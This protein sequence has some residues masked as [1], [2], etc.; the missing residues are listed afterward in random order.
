MK[1]KWKKSISEEN[2][3]I[4][5]YVESFPNDMWY[6]NIFKSYI[7]NIA[8]YWSF[9]REISTF[10]IHTKHYT[11][12]SAKTCLETHKKK[13]HKVRGVF[14]VALE[15]PIVFHYHMLK[16]KNWQR[17]ETAFCLCL[18]AR[19]SKCVNTLFISLRGYNPD[20]LFIY[21]GYLSYLPIWK[22]A[23]GKIPDIPEV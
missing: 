12:E 7:I 4:K 3:L 1:Q 14:V 23:H 10:S 13:K 19:S 20:G 11:F 5:W 22:S 6:K 18:Y 16:K 17:P 15:F 9:Y 21:F 2:S 8:E